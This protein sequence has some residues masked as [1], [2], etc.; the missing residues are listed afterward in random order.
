MKQFYKNHKSLINILFV[1]LGIVFLFLVWDVASRSYNSPYVFP[2]VI[3]TFA[4]LGLLLT[5]KSIYLSTLTTLGMALLAII[6]SLIFG[7]VFGV[8]SFYIEPLRNF[9]RPFVSFF[10][11]I[12]TVCVVIL[13]ILFSKGFAS[14]LIIVFLV[15]FPIMYESTLNG[16]I[17]IDKYI[18][19]SC[20]MEGF[21]RPKVF[22]KVLLPMSFPYINLGLIQ[23]I[24]LGL[25]VE[26]MSEIL[27][28]YGSIRGLGFLIYEAQSI[29][30]NFIDIYSYVIIVIFVYGIIDLLLFLLRK[31]IKEKIN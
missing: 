12:P 2:N 26:I 3:D 6:F 23:S 21:Y 19:E 9:L 15:I 24:G 28:G 20:K 27:I 8:L 4:N 25:K 16:F 14:Y 30:F 18:I 17:N 5:Q 7:F 22:L 11:I 31:H 29:T 1:I 10:K 13:L